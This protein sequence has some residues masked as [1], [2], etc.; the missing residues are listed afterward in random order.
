MAETTTPQ[1]LEDLGRVLGDRTRV[2][3]P[4]QLEQLRLL[5]RAYEDGTLRADNPSLARRWLAKVT[6]AFQP[7]LPSAEGPISTIGIRG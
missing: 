4:S 2:M 6:G 5:M 1:S 7:D 3:S